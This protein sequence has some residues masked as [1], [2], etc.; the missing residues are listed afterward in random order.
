MARSRLDQ[1]HRHGECLMSKHPALEQGTEHVDVIVIASDWATASAHTLLLPPGLLLSWSPGCNNLR[2]HLRECSYKQQSKGD[3]ALAQRSAH[4]PPTI[5]YKHQ[6]HCPCPDML[7][8][9]ENM[10]AVIAA[11]SPRNM[12]IQCNVRPMAHAAKKTQ[13]FTRAINSAVDL[14][15]PAPQR[16]GLR[17]M[18][19]ARAPALS[20]ICS[21]RAHHS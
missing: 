14:I 21:P 11:P 17:F 9:T 16:R 18:C 19:K 12:L 20:E 15:S 8:S 4:A 7:S 2:E 10:P 5:L 1:K 3:P 13:R 6:H